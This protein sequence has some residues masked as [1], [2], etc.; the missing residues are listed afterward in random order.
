MYRD[1]VLNIDIVDTR[2]KPSFI[3]IGENKSTARFQQKSTISF[4]VSHQ[5]LCKM[6]IQYHHWTPAERISA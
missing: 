4:R 5:K 2:F 3:N 6:A 1:S